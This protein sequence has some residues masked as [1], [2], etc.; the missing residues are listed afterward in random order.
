MNV[1]SNKITLQKAALNEAELLH[2]MKY[3]A[4]LP[5]YERYHDDETSPVKESIDKVIRLLQSQNTDY[6]FIL[7]D[8][9]RV[10]AIRIVSDG[11]ANGKNIYR[12]SPLFVLP[13]YQNRGIGYNVLLKVFDMYKQADMW[14]LSTI[15]EEKANCHLYE[16]CGFVRTGN[17]EK[18]NK[19]MTIVYYEKEVHNDCR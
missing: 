6:Y 10:G 11:N 17:E 16:K 3:T 1:E 4:F 9:N 5:L 7:L 14:R 18:I 19:D 13:E 12:I 2:K 15:K 8:T